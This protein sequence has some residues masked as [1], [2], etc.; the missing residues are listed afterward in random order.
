[1]ATD[2]KTN[3]ENFWMTRFFGGSSRG[4]CVQVTQERFDYDPDAGGAMFNTFQLTREDAR[5][6]AVELMLFAEGR[7]QEDFG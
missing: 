7:E 2:L 5:Q 6:L 4:T 1:M 3:G